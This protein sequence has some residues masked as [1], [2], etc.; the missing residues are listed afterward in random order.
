MFPTRARATGFALSDGIG[1]L[2]GAI[3]PFIFSAIVI[4]EVSKIVLTG[5]DFFILLGILEIVAAI[6]LFAG[7]KTTNKSLEVIS[8]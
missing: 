1:H 5:S 6:V 3:V 2:G 8:P 4:L 7:P